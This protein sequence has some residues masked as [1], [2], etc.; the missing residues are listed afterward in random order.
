MKART[1]ALCALLGAASC[2]NAQTNVYRWVDK[3]GKVQF[4][5][6]PPP[7][8]AKDATQKRFGGGDTDDT[9]LPYATQIAKRRNPVIL[10]VS[11]DCGDAC[12]KG[13]DLLER[14]GV[15]YSERD[16]QASAAD[17]E[18]LKA[19]V[20]ALY[21]PTLVVGEAKTKG[22]EEDSWQSALDGAGYPRTRLPGQASM[23]IPSKSPD[24]PPA[25]PSSK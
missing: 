10:Y 24:S 13:R 11:A 21:V 6:S 9:S 12:V 7:A 23:R 20:G 5:D 4:S 22:F 2:A 16:V 25:E 15:P 3:D 14:R 8:D 1:I 19:L 18:A 17:Q